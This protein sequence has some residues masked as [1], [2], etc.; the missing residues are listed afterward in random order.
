MAAVVAFGAAQGWAAKPYPD[1]GSRTTV[2]LNGRA[3]NGWFLCDAVDAPVIYAV[4]AVNPPGTATVAAFSKLASGAPLTRKLKVGAADPGAGQI[5]Y[6]L[7]QGRTQ[8]GNIHA[9]NPAMLDDPPAALTPP[10]TSMTLDRRTVQCRWSTGVRLLGFDQRRTFQIT[11]GSD[12]ALTYSTFD[13][14]QAGSSRAVALSAGQRATKPTLSIRGGVEAASRTG[15]TF[16]FQNDG[17]RY[18][19]AVDGSAPPRV[20]VSHAGKTVQTE[21]L[22]AWTFA[23]PPAGR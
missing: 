10:F 15:S 5:Y 17:Y 13:F 16:A 20:T 12:G 19:V 22:I 7:N 3:V 4:T 11:Q 1:T 8:V 23:P 6:G 18:E 14:A 9:I 2:M 21:T